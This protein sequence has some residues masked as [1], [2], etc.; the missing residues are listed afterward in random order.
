MWNAIG[1][2]LPQAV[3]IASSPLPIVVLLLMLVSAKGR[4]NGPAFACG[5]TI[6]VVTLVI[7]AFSLAD[8]IDVADSDGD[9]G[10]VIHL[11]L[12]LVFVVLAVSQWRS[13]PRPGVEPTTPKILAAVDRA[14]PGRA[15]GLAVA[16][17]VVNPKNLPLAI[18]AG[19]HLSS[20][21]VDGGSGVTAAI[22]LGVIASASVL[23]P[24][25]VVLVA[26]DLSHDALDRTKTWLLTNNATIMFVLFTVLG[27]KMFGAG[28]GLLD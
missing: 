7:L 9:R 15:F 6:S 1:Q 8:G 13:R 14:T 4:S 18:S 23:V 27:A 11:A 2:A 12:G 22:V 25:V 19:V 20:A 26:G 17:A 16:V 10:R 3:G 28:L 5:W 21:G 24:V